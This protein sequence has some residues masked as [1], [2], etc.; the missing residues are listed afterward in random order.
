MLVFGFYNIRRKLQSF[1]IKEGKQFLHYL[2]ILK[3]HYTVTVD[4]KIID[5]RYVASLYVRR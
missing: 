3:C 2:I 1:D 4:L 5:Y